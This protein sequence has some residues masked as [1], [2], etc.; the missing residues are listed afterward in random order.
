MDTNPRLTDD[1]LDDLDVNRLSQ[2]VI[3]VTLPTIGVG[4]RSLNTPPPPVMSPPG[5]TISVGTNT[6]VTHLNPP[7]MGVG[8]THALHQQVGRARTPPV[9]TYNGGRPMVG[10]KL[11]P[12]RATTGGKQP[13]RVPRENTPSS[14]SDGGCC[15]RG[16]ELFF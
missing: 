3:Y 11:T 10:Y 4:G 13:R 6:S 2:Y 14:S 5:P 7:A 15:E 1:W 12:R 9:A 16:H 8:A